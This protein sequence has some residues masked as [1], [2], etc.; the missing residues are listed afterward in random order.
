MRCSECAAAHGRLISPDDDSAASAGPVVVLSHRLF[1]RRFAGDPSVLGTTIR[2][3][4]HDFTV[5]GV[6]PEPFAGI[7][8]GSPRDVW[9]PL[10]TLRRLDPTAA[11][12]DQRRASWLEMFGRLKPGVTLEQARA[13]LSVI[14]QR[15]EQTYPDT[16]TRAGVGVEP[17][18]GRDVD[19]QR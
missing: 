11:R 18:L 6:T 8:V 2:V 4:G 14:A 12:F 15:L 3:D 17:G 13:E 7:K 16:N 9:V 10:V 5:I 1:Q 19:V